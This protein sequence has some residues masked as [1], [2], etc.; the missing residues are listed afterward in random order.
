MVMKL[1]CDSP[2]FLRRVTQAMNSYLDIFMGITNFL[3]SKSLLDCINYTIDQQIIWDTNMF[4]HPVPSTD[5]PESITH[6][7][8]TLRTFKLKC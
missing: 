7:D 5:A 3:I 1:Q 6:D 2:Y 8:L 4:F